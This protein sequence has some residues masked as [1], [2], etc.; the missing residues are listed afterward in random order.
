MKII[1]KRIETGFILFL[2]AI[3]LPVAEAKGPGKVE[4]CHRGNVITVGVAAQA[5]HF[6]H[7]DPEFF[8]VDEAGACEEQEEDSPD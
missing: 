7:G 4:V 8:T 1:S 2:L 5:A 6:A 3:L